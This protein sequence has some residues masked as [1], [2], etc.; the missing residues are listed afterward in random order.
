MKPFVLFILIF[1]A[2]FTISISAAERI[3][4]PVKFGNLKFRPNGTWVYVGAS[5]SEEKLAAAKPAIDA[6]L[7]RCT[8]DGSHPFSWQ[9][10]APA[11]VTFIIP[12]SGDIDEIHTDLAKYSGNINAAWIWDDIDPK[13]GSVSTKIFLWAN[14]LGYVDLY[15]HG[16]IVCSM[17]CRT[18]ARSKQPHA[19]VWKVGEVGS[20]KQGSESGRMSRKWKAW[21]PWAL[22]ITNSN[23][24]CFLHGGNLLSA[25]DGCVRLPRPG[26]AIVYHLL[27]AGSEIE[28]VYLD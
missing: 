14:G 20:Q 17:P 25:S 13:A 21:M 16:K 2:F 18:S 8:K 4:P 28:V 5:V 22:E 11:G 10:L 15:Q 1:Q 12:V 27:K 23:P 7:D 9:A 3:L 26:A 24:G 6:V 19:G